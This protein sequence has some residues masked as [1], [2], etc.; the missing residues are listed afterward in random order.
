MVQR[1]ARRAAGGQS[2]MMMSR[3][4]TGRHCWSRSLRPDQPLSFL[5]KRRSSTAS[6]EA[7]AEPR[8]SSLSLSHPEGRGRRA[9]APR[10]HSPPPKSGW[11]RVIIVG[12]C[13]ASWQKT[14]GCRMGFCSCCCTRVVVGCRVGVVASCWFWGVHGGGGGG[15]V[16]ERRRRAAQSALQA[17]HVTGTGAQRREGS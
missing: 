14:P 11:L 8:P 16:P 10:W 13:D 1:D 6:S 4:G 3:K 9:R 12:V 5:R 7:A 15:S 2:G 17:Q